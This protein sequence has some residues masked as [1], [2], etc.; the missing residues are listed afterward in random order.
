MADINRIIALIDKYLE[1][2]GLNRVEAN[3][4][5]IYL[6]KDGVLRHSTD[7]PGSPLR[8]LL[9]AGKIPNAEQPGGKH[10]SWYIRHS[11]GKISLPSSS[12]K[13]LNPSVAMTNVLTSCNITEGLKPV[14]DPE[15]EFLI[16]GTLPGKESLKTQHYYA[17]QSNQFWEI[18]SNMFGE[19]MPVAYEDRLEFLRK[20]KI[21]LW[22]VLKSA[23]RVSSLDSD[24][25]NPEFNDISGFISSHPK[26]RVIGLNGGKAYTYFRTYID[27]HKLPANIRI[28]HLPSSSSAN[29]H[30]AV[31]AKTVSWKRIISK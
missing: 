17:N 31:E 23:D 9:R 27:I 15:S 21:A 8:K 11:N 26:I 1:I 22:D 2:T 28:V 4:I 20:H 3:E 25:K 5:S 29:T 24:I 6:E 10:T 12:E 18:I 16:L 13:I 7:R 30:L 14:A 19:N